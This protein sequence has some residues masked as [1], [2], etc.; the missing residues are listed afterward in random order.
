MLKLSSFPAIFLAATLVLGG[1]SPQPADDSVLEEMEQPAEIAGSS[2]S[3][4]S[5][6]D[7]EVDR[8]LLS[9]EITVPKEFFEDSTEAEIMAAAEEAGFTST[10]INEDGSVT[11]TMPRRVHDELLQE[12]KDGIDEVIAEALQEN[13]QIFK[14]VSYDR[15]VTKFKVTVNRAAFESSFEA[16]FIGFGLGLGGMF[17]QIYQ[18]VP[19]DDQGVIIDFVDEASG[20]VFDSQRWPGDE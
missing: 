14:D 13:P 7:V 4:P 9:V 2:E 18:G 3:E 12:M 17:Y 11:Y 6:A 16:P 8:G 15:N 1:C 19:K 10:V 5:V 20:D